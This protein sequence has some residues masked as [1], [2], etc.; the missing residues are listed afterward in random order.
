MDSKVDVEK[1][2]AEVISDLQAAIIAHQN[3]KP[4]VLRDS[5]DKT[6]RIIYQ[7]NW[8]R[9]KPK[10]K[11]TYEVWLKFWNEVSP[12]E[13][14][15][16]TVSSHFKIF[17]REEKESLKRYAA[18]YPEHFIGD[19]F[20]CLQCVNFGHNPMFKPRVKPRKPSEYS[21]DWKEKKEIAATAAHLYVYLYQIGKEQEECWPNFVKEFLDEYGIDF[22]DLRNDL[23]LKLS[24]RDIMSQYYGE[25]FKDRFWQTFVV[26][27]PISLR[28]IRSLRRSNPKDNPFLAS[29][30]AEFMN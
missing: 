5:K 19:M 20:A 26:E 21:L 12:E 8:N 1:I 27:G 6:I 15:F 3:E 4:E 29:L 18:E 17:P 22:V 25:K 16:E 11:A 23:Q 28:R 14:D 2:L 10:I 30:F 13:C 24:V 7:F 9:I